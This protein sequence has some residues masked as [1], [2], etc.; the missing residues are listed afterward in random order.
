[1]NLGG[2]LVGQ[3]ERGLVLVGGAIRVGEEF[4][5]SGD[6]GFGF[7]DGGHGRLEAL[8]V[9]FSNNVGGVDETVNKKVNL[10]SGVKGVDFIRYPSL[11]IQ[12]HFEASMVS[13]NTFVGGLFR[14]GTNEEGGLQD[15][16]W[17]VWSE[18]GMKDGKGVTS[19]A[20]EV[21]WS[22]GVGGKHAFDENVIGHLCEP[23]FQ[24]IRQII[25]K[26]IANAESPR[27]TVRAK[28]EIVGA[29]VPVIPTVLCK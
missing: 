25:I 16:G 5:D 29:E 7:I 22:R 14:R 19:H 18:D 11:E 21:V 3:A 10:V 26:V 1:M 2:L 17:V 15:K 8:I 9:G 13:R 4:G 28:I 20:K 23:K 24:A 12:E 27:A 6:D